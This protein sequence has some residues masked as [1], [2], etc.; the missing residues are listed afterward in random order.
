MVL[1][2]PS[3]KYFSLVADLTKPVRSAFTKFIFHL[4]LITEVK[5]PLSSCVGTEKH[6]S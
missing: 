2:R 3:L 1:I 5:S 6:V 4:I